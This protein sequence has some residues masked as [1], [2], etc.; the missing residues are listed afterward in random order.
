[1]SQKNFSNKN[2]IDQDVLSQE[3]LPVAPTNSKHQKQELPETASIESI[4]FMHGSPIKFAKICE[5]TGAPR[6]DVLESCEELAASYIQRQA[7]LRITIHED[8][9]QMV[10]EKS[11]HELIEKFMQKELEGDLSNPALEVLAIIAYRGPLSKPDVEAIRG[12]NCSFTVRNLLLRG[13]IERLPH[14]TD[15]RTKLYHVTHNFLRSL[16]L[17]SIEQLP[18]WENLVGDKRIDAILYGQVDDDRSK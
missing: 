15:K 12:V 5:I 3:P 9:I 16:G 6:K 14:P 4:L 13:L 7:G 18:Q 17:E 10:T 2:R 1:M 8:T 11:Q